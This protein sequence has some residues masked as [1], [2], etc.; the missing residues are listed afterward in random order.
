MR[1]VITYMCPTQGHTGVGI[2][3]VCVTQSD[4]FRYALDSYR[5]YI[6]VDRN[7]HSLAMEME[8]GMTVRL[9]YYK[10]QTAS[11]TA[12]VTHAACTLPATVYSVTH[13]HSLHTGARQRCTCVFLV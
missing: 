3:H 10:H 8:V 1:D 6:V 2:G 9:G 4:T 11:P 7:R 13:T 12:A 5:Y